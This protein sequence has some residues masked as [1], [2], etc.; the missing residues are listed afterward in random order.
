VARWLDHAERYRV[1]D[2]HFRLGVRQAWRERFAATSNYG[3]IA[4]LVE[5]FA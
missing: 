5:M 2:P 3:R 4:R 1:L